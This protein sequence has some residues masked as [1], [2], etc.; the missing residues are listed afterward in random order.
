[1]HVMHLC[2][3]RFSQTFKIF[4]CE[5]YNNFTQ[6]ISCIT[7]FFRL[8]TNCVLGFPQP[9]F[10]KY[11]SLVLSLYS[12]KFI[13]IYIFVYIFIF[14]LLMKRSILNKLFK[15][16]CSEYCRHLKNLSFLRNT[17][18]LFKTQFFKFYIII[19]NVWIFY[20][21]EIMYIYKYI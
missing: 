13:L 7:G 16:A 8:H 12:S 4:I 11:E 3:L 1:M 21:L 20:D 14:L 19:V 15:A 2:E 6:V 10:H 17:H 5:K 9:I 18:I